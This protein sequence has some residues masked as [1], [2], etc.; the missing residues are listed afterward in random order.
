MK[1]IAITLFL[2]SS[3][4]HAETKA[5]YGDDGRIEVEES[6]NP[7]H[8]ELAASVAA[9]IPSYVA[10]FSSE[11]VS[12]FDI[13]LKDTSN[14]CSEERF[15]HQQTVSTCTGLL[16]GPKHIATAGHC[17]RS[18]ID[19]EYSRW[20]FDYKLKSEKDSLVGDIPISQVYAC[21][22]I[23]GTEL[24]DFTKKDWAIVELDRPVTGRQPLTLVDS[25][26]KKGAEV[27][28]I[29]TPS[30]LPLKVATGKV[31]SK[32]FNYF[33]TSLDT[34]TGNSGSPV[35]NDQNEVIGILVR[36]NEDY[37]ETENQC[38]LSSKYQESRGRE[39][40]S[41]IKDILMFNF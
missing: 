19:C 35:F 6:S 12:F 27:F 22:K 5:I 21:T 30:G 41:Y 32:R 38:H 37:Y 15:A 31:L 4:S 7:A 20:V 36:G 3:L 8:R 26:P 34:F 17:V 28:V 33:R 40:V 9:M 23:I 11:Y 2:L 14:V 1:F 39:E 16:V 25:K 10:D 13:T 29:G 24:N 18:M